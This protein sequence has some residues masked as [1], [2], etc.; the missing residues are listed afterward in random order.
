[1][2]VIRVLLAD[3]SEFVRES[4]TDLLASSGQMEVVAQCADG[5]DVVDA[6]ER[7]HPDVV[8]LDLVMPVVDGLEAARR[9]LAAR[10]D[11]RVV[12]LTGSLSRAAVFE[13]RRLGAYGYLLKAED[14]QDLV[15]ALRIVAAGGSAWS[16]ATLPG[17]QPP[18]V[19]D[20]PFLTT[21]GDDGSV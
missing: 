9:L 8:L 15:D 5:T 20:G 21:R 16:S 4:L 18:P 11:S 17:S 3:D 19:T 2:T 12:M 1:V 6:A 7:T 13:A 10:P 14:P